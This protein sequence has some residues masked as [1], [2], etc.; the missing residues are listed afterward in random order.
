MYFGSMKS[1]KMPKNEQSRTSDDP[2]FL[3]VIPKA[4]SMKERTH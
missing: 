2:A 4:Q 3:V 1:Y